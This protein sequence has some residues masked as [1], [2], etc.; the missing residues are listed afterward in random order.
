M[1]GWVSCES[2]VAIKPTVWRSFPLPNCLHQRVSRVSTVMRLVSWRY[3]RPRD[4]HI[5]K[6]IHIN[7]LN[8]ILSLIF[9]RVFFRTAVHVFGFFYQSGT[10]L[11]GMLLFI[12]A[13]LCLHGNRCK[14]A[15]LK[16]KSI[17]QGFRCVG[18]LSTAD[19]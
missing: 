2:H 19:N 11:I 17:A 3:E 9:A 7:H 12:L 15:I 16:E 6:S 14:Q 18:C 10:K 5:H 8:L 1:G 4:R 13:C